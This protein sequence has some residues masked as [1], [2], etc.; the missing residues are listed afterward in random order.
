MENETNTN[1]QNDKLYFRLW[2]EQEQKEGQQRL[3]ALIEEQENEEIKGQ[4]IKE[5]LEVFDFTGK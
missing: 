3:N 2:E 1:T 4:Q 5:D